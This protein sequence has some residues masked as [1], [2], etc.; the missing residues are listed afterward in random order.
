MRHDYSL[1]LFLGFST[2]LCS[3]ADQSL[4]QENVVLRKMVANQKLKID[5][6]E[7]YMELKEEKVHALNREI[8]S[9]R[10]ALNEERAKKDGNGLYL[11]SPLEFMY[12]GQ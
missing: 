2:S 6:L 10:S 1:L 3:A 11:E 8:I 4:Y 12:R 5:E 9:L 7:I